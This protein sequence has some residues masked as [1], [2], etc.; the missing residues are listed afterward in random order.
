MFSASDDKGKLS[1]EAF[2]EDALEQANVERM[3]LV[4]YAGKRDD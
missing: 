1:L 3:M 2:P 4:V